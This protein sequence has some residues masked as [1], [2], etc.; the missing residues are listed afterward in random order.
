LDPTGKLAIQLVFAACCISA[1]FT[2]LPRVLIG[3]A[4]QCCRT[5][6]SHQ[7]NQR[8]CGKKVSTGLVRS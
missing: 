2:N 3:Y 7:R 8:R 4:V 5:M 1:A 6:G